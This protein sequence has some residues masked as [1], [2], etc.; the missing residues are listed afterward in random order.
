MRNRRTCACSCASGAAPALAR[1]SASN[2]VTCPSVPT[3][4]IRRSGRVVGR[5]NHRD[6]LGPH[7]GHQPGELGDSPGEGAALAGYLPLG[8]DKIRQAQ[9][10]TEVVNNAGII[11]RRDG[12]ESFRMDL[13][14]DLVTMV[15]IAR[16][17]EVK[18][19]MS[20][21]CS[22]RQRSR[23]GL[24][25]ERSRETISRTVSFLAPPTGHVS[26]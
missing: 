25:V 17:A 3:S 18:L 1:Y 22:W 10:T 4:G 14:D 6:A 24:T 2:R 7:L 11:L 23:I 21:S 15:D 9:L 16:L 19:P 5:V 26:V 12:P 20:R 8:D 13:S